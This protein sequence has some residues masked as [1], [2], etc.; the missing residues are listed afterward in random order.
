M[1]KPKGRKPRTV[2]E[3]RAAA[4]LRETTVVLSFA[5][6]RMGEAEDLQRQLT[7]A[8]TFKAASMADVDPRPALVEQLE[9]L[10]EEIEANQAEFH[11]RALPARRW[12]DL[13]AAHPA[14]AG[15]DRVFDEATFPAAAIAACCVDP[16]MTLAEYRELAEVLSIGQEDALFEAVWRINTKAAASVPFSLAS[17]AILASLTAGN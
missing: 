6:D 13:L 15:S 3:L 5:G 12:S 8:S 1:P 9:A 11:L 17:S 14:P 10:Q 16:V 4:A 7:E 2:Q